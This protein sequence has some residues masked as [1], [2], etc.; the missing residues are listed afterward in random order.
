M[1]DTKTISIIDV[2]TTGLSPAKHDRIVEIGIVQIDPKGQVVAEYETLVNP[3]RDLGPQHIHQIS[4]ED[5]LGAPTFPDIAPDILKHLSPS[6][7]VAG[8]NISFDVNFLI[9]E[10]RRI[11]VEIPKFIPFCTCQFFGR[12]KLRACCEELGIYIEGVEHC[13]IDD[14]RATAQIVAL[15]LGSDP[16]I[17]VP[18]YCTGLAWPSLTPSTRNP[19]RRSQAIVAREKTPT[20]LQRIID[21]AHHDTEAELPSVLTYMALIDRVL[22]DRVI[23]DSEQ[24]YLVET[25]TNLGL[26]ATQVKTAHEHYIHNLIV[27]ALSDGVI[28]KAEN[29]DLQLVARLLG[30]DASALNKT[31]STL[32]S[33]TKPTPSDATE[34]LKVN[35]LAGKTVCF[36]GQLQATIGG[37][38]LSRDTA[39]MLA[40]KAGCKIASS[41]TKK[42]DVLVVADPAT[43]SG[44]AKKAREYGI[45]ILADTVFWKLLGVIVD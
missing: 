33:Q 1:S 16:D 38:T 18:Y 12:P 20:F 2:E 28:T 25:A 34:S 29:R 24:E 22:E 42:L 3:N 35:E 36:T 32:Q 19:Y 41:V 4:S 5:I 15:L 9:A 17:L 8:H 30:Y 11:G 43:Q 40:A 10:F 37:H 44:K 39:E 13:A 45:R 31:L 7:L 6:V 27:A 26:T 21:S 23:D 14:A